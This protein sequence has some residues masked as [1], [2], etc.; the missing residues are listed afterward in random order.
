M[1]R[2]DGQA[3]VENLC[4]RGAPS[5]VRRWSTH[6]AS[7]VAGAEH[8]TGRLP[9]SNLRSGVEQVSNLRSGVEQVSNLLSGVEQVSNL[10]SGVAQVSNLLSGVAQVSNL[11]G[12]S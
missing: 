5:Q 9:V 12:A 4:Y 11:L 6:H 10:R 3:Q 7:A 1:R 8:V 2:R